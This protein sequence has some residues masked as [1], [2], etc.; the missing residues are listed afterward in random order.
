MPHRPRLIAASALAA[1]VTM[2]AVIPASADPITDKQRQAQQIADEIERLGDAA[3]DLG[4]RYNG[5]LVQLQQADA[6][7]K[8]AE[9]KLADLE[10]K[11]GTVRTA[12]G[13]FAVRAYVY[14]DQTSGVAAMLT[15]TSLSDGSAQREGYNE[16]ALGNTS[17]VTDGMKALIEDA[18]RQKADLDAKRAQQ[19]NLAEV[20]KKRQEAA[21]SAQAKQQQAL[22]KVKGELNT[23]VVKEQQRRAAEA[24]RQAEV[25][26]QQA[27][28]ALLASQQRAAAA[29][30][31]PSSNPS[32]AATGTVNRTVT[33][34]D[35][36]DN[37]EDTGTRTNAPQIDIPSTSPGAATAVRAALGQLGVPYRFA[38]ASPGQAF[39]CSGLTQ[40]AW[41]QAGVSLPH[42]AASQYG[43]LP[44]VP[45]DQLQPGDL[46]F[47]YSDLH[48]VGI[49]I[50][51]G[52]MVHA[53]RTGDVVK[54]SPLQ[55]RN[56]VGAARP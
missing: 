37:G 34:G 48:H 33:A 30:A 41:A 56:L 35:V 6:D 20:T 51:N 45:L 27:Q 17:D 22:V 38:A 47:F 13:A 54:V 11:L 5:A 12:A 8:D 24:A 25:A 39:D 18:D 46:V 55:G 2:S 49:Y 15:G 53:P 4:E 52:M 31:A 19:A 1:L 14:A 44:H 29:A 43:M 16:V 36:G 50:G 10:A 21:E 42:F 9:A 7:V 23:L 28:A 3:A 26:K 32:T 40:W